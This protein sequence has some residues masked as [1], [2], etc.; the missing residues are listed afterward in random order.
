MELKNIL[1]P[2][3][4]SECSK[5]ALK[6]AIK[7]AKMAKAK[8]HMVNAV[9]VHTPHPDLSGGSLFDSIV[10]DYESQIQQSFEELESEIIELKKIPHESDRFISYLTDAIYSE[11]ENK[12]IDLIVMGTR[13]QHERIEHLLGT[14][15]TDVIEFSKVPVLVIPEKH[16]GFE[17]KK[18]G[19]ASDLL[20]GNHEGNLH[21]LKW[22]IRQFNSELVVFHVA[23]NAK[24]L[25][26]KERKQMDKITKTFAGMNFSIQTAE[27][28]SVVKGI[29]QFTEDHELDLLAMMPRRHNL[30][31]R[32]FK[33][34]TTKTVAID[35]NMPLLAFHD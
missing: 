4:F 8:I 2:I 32:L 27:Y 23:E 28:D 15:A 31:H 11:S 10:G 35:L 21:I 19:F 1:V 9:H 30:F 26:S 16:E 24:K 3:D 6:I 13:D 7:L 20:K 17:P 33:A 25:G 14:H 34:S 22:F 18:V 5:N 29:K 12:N